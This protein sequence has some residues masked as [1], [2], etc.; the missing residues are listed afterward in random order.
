MGRSPGRRWSLFAKPIHE[1]SVT[2]HPFDAGS[3]HSLAYEDAQH[4][5]IR[6]ILLA[7]VSLVI[8]ILASLPA[9]LVVDLR[10]GVERPIGQAASL[11]ISHSTLFFLA[12]VLLGLLG[13]SW[14]VLQALQARSAISHR[15]SALGTD[16]EDP[17]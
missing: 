11:I 13:I 17:L 6:E 12:I 15:Q 3:K 1:P 9:R 16:T 4:M 5:V 7:Y 14:R 2:D 8:A 10:V